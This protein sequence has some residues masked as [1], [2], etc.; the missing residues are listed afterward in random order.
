MPAATLSDY[1]CECAN[2]NAAKT[3]QTYKQGPVVR[4]D[5][6]VREVQK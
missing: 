4:L 2:P 5:R 3:P 1:Q 6:D